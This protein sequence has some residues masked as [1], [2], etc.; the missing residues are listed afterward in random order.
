MAI[1]GTENVQEWI[2]WA[3]HKAD[4]YD[5]TVEKKD[6]YLNPFGEL[7]ESLLD[8]KKQLDRYNTDEL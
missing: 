6:E 5:P 2:Q 4:W 8:G 3:K 7:H 1:E